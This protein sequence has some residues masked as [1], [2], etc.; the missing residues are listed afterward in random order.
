MRKSACPPGGIANF[1]KEVV[2]GYRTS[3]LAFSESMGFPRVVSEAYKRTSKFIQRYTFR[4][5]IL[6]RVGMAPPRQCQ[7]CTIAKGWKR[8]GAYRTQCCSRLRY[9]TQGAAYLYSPASRA[10]RGRSPT[11][12]SGRPPQTCAA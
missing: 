6:P 3:C 12:A 10:A 8:K 1:G 5:S 11:M 4:D 9:P 7:P 2:V